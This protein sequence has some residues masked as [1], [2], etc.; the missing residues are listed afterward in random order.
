[1]P[2]NREL[3]STKQLSGGDREDIYKIMM[4]G[5]DC[6]RNI[7]R[8]LVRH[9][10]YNDPLRRKAESFPELLEPESLHR[11][12]WFWFAI[13]AIASI[14]ALIS[15][16]APLPRSWAPS[17]FF[18]HISSLVSCS[19]PTSPEIYASDSKIPEPAIPVQTFNRTDQVQFDNYS[20]IL[21]GQ[22]ILLQCVI[23]YLVYYYLFLAL[24]WLWWS[25]LESFTHSG[26]PYLLYGLIFSKS[27]KPQDWM[28]LAS[29]H[30]W[31]WST[32]HLVWSISTVSVH[33]S[34]CTTQHETRGF[35]L[36]WDLA[37]FYYRPSLFDVNC[38]LQVQ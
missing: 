27:S 29:T 13:C 8:H 30:I 38:Y 35:G 26:Y 36:S 17:L 6:D 14:F 25:V 9:S 4:E 3:C 32:R 15:S 34:R 22:R 18:F 11:S 23:S 7:A 20:L 1:M 24:G 5:Y 12:G 28:Q 31:V 19:S 37:C 10:Y 16:R 33:C 2:L 21:R